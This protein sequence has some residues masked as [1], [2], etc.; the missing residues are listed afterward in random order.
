MVRRYVLSAML[1]CLM[2]LPNLIVA[3]DCIF[4]ASGYY[5]DE[6]LQ[7]C[8]SHGCYSV[9]YSQKDCLSDCCLANLP[10]E[11]FKDRPELVVLRDPVDGDP[12]WSQYAIDTSSYTYGTYGGCAGCVQV[13]FNALC[14][15]R[16]GQTLNMQKLNDCMQR[17]AENNIPGEDNSFQFHFDMVPP[18]QRS[19]V[20]NFYKEHDNIIQPGCEGYLGEVGTQPL[21]G[22]GEA[23]SATEAG[24][25]KDVKCDNNCSVQ[26]PFSLLSHSGTCF[27]TS[28]SAY[29]C[30]YATS[31]CEWGCNSARD[32]CADAPSVQVQITQPVDGAKIDT[33]QSGVAT[34]SVSGSTIKS[35]MYGIPKV[36]I[37]I[38]SSDVRDAVYD[39]STGQFSLS[40]VQIRKGRPVT[41]TA[42]V[43]SQDG[44]RLG[45]D[46]INVYPNPDLMTF[47]WTI[48]Q[49]V[50]I[51]HNGQ[52]VDQ[53]AL[54]EN[55]KIQE[56]D[57]FQL[58]G[59]GMISLEY[60]D[61]TSVVLMSPSKMSFWDGAVHVTY[62]AIEVN[63]QHD[64]EV[65]GR[66]GHFVVKGTKFA[67]IVPEDASQPDTLIVSG[68]T[69]TAS[70]IGS[71]DKSVD[72]AAGKK[73]DIYPNTVVT[74]DS[75]QEATDADYART[76]SGKPPG[77]C[78]AAFLL[79]VIAGFALVKRG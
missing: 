47:H 43:Y 8:K 15:P 6:N 42:I 71:E 77:C 7:Y 52:A 21:P 2:A 17:C 63:A 55:Y 79:L 56:G 33:G 41:V 35:G 66:Q 78:G 36:V 62:G 64:Y 9:Y 70:A 51:Y 46:T 34:I 39:Y 76:P 1:L 27:E 31:E 50:T 18:T 48:N 67:V 23:P 20:C 10:G 32:G 44:K 72:V 45:S 49:G 59:S 75:V 29:E 12:T 68:G 69:V 3:Y 38:G 65:L 25:C 4:D 5:P 16:E 60:S 28:S 61:G 26:G 22:G 14:M 30:R 57:E 74:G 40:N 19:C 54:G 73:I 11:Y 53:D 58:S 37:A 24:P 13:S